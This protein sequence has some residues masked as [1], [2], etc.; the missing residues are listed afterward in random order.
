MEK[1]L[2]PFGEYIGDFVEDLDSSYMKFLTNQTWFEDKYP[3]LYK[4]F[5]EEL[6]ERGDW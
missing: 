3:N 1:T 6:K 5:T 4:E 2:M